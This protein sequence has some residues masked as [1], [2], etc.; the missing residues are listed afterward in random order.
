MA[1]LL[2][3]YLAAYRASI[4]YSKVKLG[5]HTAAVAFS[6]SFAGQ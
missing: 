6:R 5:G 2:T 1:D 3:E 4:G